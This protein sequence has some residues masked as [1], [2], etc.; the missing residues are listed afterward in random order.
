MMV[1]FD[2]PAVPVTRLP[3][4]LTETSI[5]AVIP[6]RYHSTRFPGKALVDIAGRPLIEHVY[7]RASAATSIDALVVATD[8]ERIARTVEGFGGVACMT[9]PEHVSGTDRLAE[10][11]AAVPCGLFVNVQGDEPLLDPSLI[12]AAVEPLRTNP[13]IVMAT[14]ARPLT[15]DAEMSNPNMVKV[16]RDHDGFALYFS[17][18]SIPHGRDA[19]STGIARVHIGLYVYRRDTLLRL[20]SLMPGPL[21]QAEAL[22]QLR[23]L[24]HGIRI[25][26][27]DTAYESCEVNTPEDVER[28]KELLAGGRHG[29][30][31][32]NK[33]RAS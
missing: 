11:A 14:A 24:E 8:D 19:L 17:R 25:N 7:R 28:V 15:S 29:T 21:E 13:G 4:T 26:V 33:L 23:A 30:H 9:S 16:V 31:A 6:A 2:V 5:L 27:V 20:A 3:F 10:I 18:A 22:E 12:D 32:V 1:E